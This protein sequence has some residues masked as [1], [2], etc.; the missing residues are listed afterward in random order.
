VVRNGDSIATWHVVMTIG[1]RQSHVILRHNDDDDS[2]NNNNA[3]HAEQAP[4]DRREV[5]ADDPEAKTSKVSHTEDA[6]SW[7][8]W[9][10]GLQCLSRN[11]LFRDSA[12]SSAARSEH[13][14][15]LS[16]VS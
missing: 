3:W 5:E 16:E 6:I 10:N 7:V 12:I 11:F 2:N 13:G 9:R 15:G 14:P 8:G 1:W 4:F